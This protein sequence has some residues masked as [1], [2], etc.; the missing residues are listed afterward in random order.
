MGCR[1][2]GTWETGVKDSYEFEN[3]EKRGKIDWRLKKDNEKQ[4]WGTFP[5]E[6]KGVG[7]RVV[8]MWGVR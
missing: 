8:A 6:T 4:T 2:K 5:P 3:V 1:G 7:D